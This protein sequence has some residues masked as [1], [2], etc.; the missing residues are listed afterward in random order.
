MSRWWLFR[1]F[2]S[3]IK[4]YLFDGRHQ[5][6]PTPGLLHYINYYYTF[7][8]HIVTPTLHHD[9]RVAKEH[10]T[11]THGAKC[12]TFVMYFSLRFQQVT[13]PSLVTQNP[14]RSHRTLSGH[15]EPYQVTQNS[16]R[17]RRTLSSHTEPYQVTQ[18]P[19]RPRRTLSGHAELSHVTHTVSSDSSAS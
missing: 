11:D 7:A 13:E 17:S 18:N 12:W 4:M 1:Y 5:W 8:K 3:A 6:T 10:V 2:V 15:A 19:L 14:P 9:T 16:H